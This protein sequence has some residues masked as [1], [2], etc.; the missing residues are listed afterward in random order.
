MRVEDSGMPDEAYWNSLFDVPAIVD[1]LR[2]AEVPG[3]IAEIGCGYGTFT[4]PVARVSPS[5]VLAFDIDPAMLEVTSRNASAAGTLNVRCLE[6]DVLE[7]GTGLPDASAGL[8]LL[9]NI[10]HF[11]ERRSLLDEV[12]RVLVSGGR[13]AILHWRKD[14]PTPRGPRNDVR[15]D[16]AL[17]IADVGGS[18][19]QPCEQPRLLGPYHW[20]II[21]RKETQK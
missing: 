16:A 18:V 1:W 20:G 13:A 4:I 14:I 15:P 21:L 11:A 2:I 3:S 6:R 7:S 19:L 10:L 9:F 8:V 17:I 5:D 12:A